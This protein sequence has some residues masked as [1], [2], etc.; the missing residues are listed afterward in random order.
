MFTGWN[1]DASS[2]VSTSGGT[3]TA[4]SALAYLKGIG[5]PSNW[6]PA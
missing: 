4:A 6:T 2:T 1:E 3:L 5:L